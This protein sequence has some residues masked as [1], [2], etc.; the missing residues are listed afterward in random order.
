[1]LHNIIIVD[2]R[3]FIKGGADKVAIM[4]AVEL[5]KHNLNVVYFCGKGPICEYLLNSNVKAICLEQSEASAKG[6]LF[7]FMQGIYNKKA[8]YRFECLLQEFDPKDT[9]IHF[10]A[11]SEVLSSALFL[12]TKRRGFQVV[13]SGHD[14]STA[15]PIGSFYNY[16]KECICSKK[17]LSLSCVFCCCHKKGYLYKL[18]YVIRQIFNRQFIKNNALNFFYLSPMSRDILQKNGIN[19]QREFMILNPVEMEFEA[20]ADVNEAETF[21]YVGRVTIEKGVSVFCEA[22]TKSGYHG[23]VIGDGPQLKQLKDRYPNVSFVGWKNSKEISEYALKS[24]ALI[25]PSLWHEIGPLT[26][27]EMMGRFNL[28][29]IVS[30]VCSGKNYIEDGINGYIF[31]TNDVGDLISKMQLINENAGKLQTNISHYFNYDIYSED[32]HIS[33]VIEAYKEILQAR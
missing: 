11:W 14:Y 20:S 17:P 19:P 31:K 26:I 21:I 6:K 32:N 8:V 24:K 7:G 27:L 28:P 33:H 12:V 9:I 2:D 10:H 25:V 30:D 23:V 18:Y 1:M 22:F 4:S 13:I 29:C 5:A 3:G 15:C 16:K